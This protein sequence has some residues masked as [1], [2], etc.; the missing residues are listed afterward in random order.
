MRLLYL[1]AVLMFLGAGVL[2]FLAVRREGTEQRVTVRTVAGPASGAV[3][4]PTPPQPVLD[5]EC[6]A[7]IEE[8]GDGVRDPKKLCE[9]IAGLRKKHGEVE[10]TPEAGSAMA[11]VAI[12]GT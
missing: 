6:L 3:T 8:Y 7:I 12:V 10:P 5:P 1:F 11:S 9:T 2:V 4:P